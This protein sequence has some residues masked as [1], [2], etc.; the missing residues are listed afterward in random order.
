MHRPLL[1]AVPLAAPGISGQHGERVR[2]LGA[3]RTAGRGAVP[4]KDVD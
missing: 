3:G 2:M 1:T 4:W